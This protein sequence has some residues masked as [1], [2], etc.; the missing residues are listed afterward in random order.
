M[1]P[2]VEMTDGSKFFCIDSLHEKGRFNATVFLAPISAIDLV[3]NDAL[4]YF[5]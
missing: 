2:L 3:K 5:G 1:T 4:P